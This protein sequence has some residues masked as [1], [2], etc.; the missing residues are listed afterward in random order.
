[1][2]GDL[3][4]GVAAGRPRDVA[5]DLRTSGGGEAAIHGAALDCDGAAHLDGAG[6][7]TG[8]SGLLGIVQGNPA[9]SAL[10]AA[11]LGGAGAAGLG[12]DGIDAGLDEALT[13]VVGPGPVRMLRSDAVTWTV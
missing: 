13:A 11:P 1:M 5:R 9:S 10:E 8:A 12:H 3:A 7:R 6:R 4:D 2:L